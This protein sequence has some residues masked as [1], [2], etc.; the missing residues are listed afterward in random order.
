MDLLGI[1]YSDKAEKVSPVDALRTIKPKGGTCLSKGVKK[2]IEVLNG[3]DASA[4]KILIILA[5]GASDDGY[6]EKRNEQN[7]LN[8]FKKNGKSYTVSFA[9]NKTD[10]SEMDETAFN[11]LANAG[12]L[13]AKNGE[14]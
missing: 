6:M 8:T 2:G 11:A 4:N 1:L 13:N 3:K 5:D 14:E 12:N 10:D 9:L 7:T